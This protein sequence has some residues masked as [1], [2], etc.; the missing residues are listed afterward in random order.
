LLWEIREVLGKAKNSRRQK[1]CY[2][3]F[4]WFE[5]IIINY[6]NAATMR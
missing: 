6:L 2:L 3:I 5:Y 4:I 1:V